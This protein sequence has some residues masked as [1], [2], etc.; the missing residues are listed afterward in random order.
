M[1]ASHQYI[2]LIFGLKV[3]QLRQQLGLSFKDL[4]AKTDMSIS[5]LNEIE[6]GKKYPKSDK[7]IALAQALETEYDELVSLKLTK[8]LA[9]IAALFQSGILDSMPL[10]MFGIEASTLIEMIL[11]APAKIN[12]FINTLFRIARNYEMGEEN[13]FFAAL[14]SY[15]EMHDN[16]FED[17]ETAVD[18]FVALAGIPA[19]PPLSI[20]ALEAALVNR[21]GYSIDRSSL[22]RYPE[23]AQFRSVYS[24]K[25]RKLYIND[26]TSDSQQVFLLAKEIGFNY[27]GLMK[28]RPYLSNAF[29]VQSFEEVL[30]NFKASYFAVALLINRHVVL[31]D[32]RHFLDQKEWNAQAFLQMMDKYGASPEMFLQRLTNL[33]P[34]YFGVPNLF[35][36]RIEDNLDNP[37]NRYIITKELHLSQ[38][39]LPHGNELREHYC[40]RWVSIGTLKQLQQQKNED[41]EADMYID[42]Q[43]SSYVNSQKQYLC[44]SLA[45]PNFPTPHSHVSVTLGL[46]VDAQSK[47]KIRFWNSKAIRTRTVHTTCERCPIQDCAE[48]AA[49]PAVAIRKGQQALISQKLDELMEGSAR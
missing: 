43:I 17:I 12:A 31:E 9:P 8:K 16:Y 1:I 45:R 36:L 33:L 47:K 3:R 49:P 37:L 7:I 46:P 19:A 44:I 27:L 22:A 21:Y 30:N 14:R 24:P 11:Q 6:K 29:T 28:E 39:H 13:F 48:R 10:E 25:T 18:D 23:L 26:D 2:R 4:A 32:L 42:A 41:S 38:M 40:R 35:F 5:Y 20:Q 34:R 15:Q